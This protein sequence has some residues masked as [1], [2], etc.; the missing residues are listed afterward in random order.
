M[1]RDP[2]VDDY[3]ARAA[4]FARP[5]LEHLRELAHRTLPDAEEAIKWGMPHFLVKGKNVAGMAA[6]KA[7]CT[8]AIHGDGRQGEAM[9]QFGRIAAVS[10]LPDDGEL[11]ARLL[12][13]RGR[14]LAR[15]TALKA[16]AVREPKPPIPMPDD[17]AVA[18]ADA[19]AAQAA[20]DRFSPSHRREYLE[21]I[22]EARTPATRGKRMAQAIEWIGEGKKRNWKYEKC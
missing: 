18:L 7:H 6:F 16:G 1:G 22:T 2:R 5:I 8:F 21:W 11:S 17:F 15:G 10:D 4:D 13:A 9:G 14:V 12:A 19:P 20:F 3:I